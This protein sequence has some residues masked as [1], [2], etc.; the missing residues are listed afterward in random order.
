MRRSSFRTTFVATAI[1]A[2]FDPLMGAHAQPLQTQNLTAT[3]VQFDDQ[4]SILVAIWKDKMAATRDLQSGAIKEWKDSG[5][6][7]AALGAHF[8]SASFSDNGETLILSILGGTWCQYGSA[9]TDPS[10]SS[11]PARI[12]TIKNGEIVHL[13]KVASYDFNSPDPSSDTS[14]SITFDAKKRVLLTNSWVGREQYLTNQILQL[15]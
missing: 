7:P 9:G 1:V 13:Q 5:I 14:T 3:T 4:K 6:R 2:L 11:C 15:Q 10:W 8:W 12:A